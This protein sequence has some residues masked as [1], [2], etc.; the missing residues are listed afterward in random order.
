MADHGVGG[1]DGL[2]GD[3]SRQAEQR[4]PEYRRHH[5]VGEILGAGFDRRAAHT[6]L[7]KLIR[8]AADDHGNGAARFSE[9]AIGE[10]R[11]YPRDML[12]KAS[13]CDQR[14]RCQ[15]KQDIS[16]RDLPQRNLDQKS[17]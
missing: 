8:I 10:R 2:V 13:L 1:I 12:I 15:S 3:Q 11:A 5:A 17:E 9:P 7:V 4:Q 6:G 14:R 16:K